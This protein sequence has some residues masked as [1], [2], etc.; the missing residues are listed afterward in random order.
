MNI[1]GMRVAFDIEGS[2][3]ILLLLHG[4]GGSAKSLAPVHQAFAQWFRVVSLDFPGFGESDIP[5]TVWGVG[6]Y[7][8]FV[9]R[10]ITKLGVQ[11]C[12][13]IAHSFGGKVTIWL[14]SHHPELVEKI[15]LVDAAGVKPKRPFTYYIK[16]YTFKTA[17]RLYQWGI[18]G[19]RNEN[20]LA[21]LYARFGSQDYV[22][23]GP[24]RGIF[25]RVV[26]QHLD[27]LLP[28]IQCPTLLVWGDQDTAT[29]VRD[30]KVME[31][32]IPDA[33]LVVF[34]GAGHFSY[35]D[36]LGRFIQIEKHFLLGSL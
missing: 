17:K 12:H 26:N 29:P 18:L 25:I 28:T 6:E 36:Q 27:E 7:A 16:V 31:A 9:Y 24:L 33:G 23:A 35:L 10:F 3:P 2:G 19:R 30:A 13:I 4:W 5:K 32:A 14:A 1:D 22:D 21:K 34:A 20:R 11:K 15:T 8:E